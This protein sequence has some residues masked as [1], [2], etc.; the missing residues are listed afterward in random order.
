MTVTA[1]APLTR[2]IRR[3][4]AGERGNNVLGF[5]MIFPLCL[6]IALAALQFAVL[7]QAKALAQGAAEEG[8]RAASAETATAGDG[9]AA[10]TA[11]AAISTTTLRD[12]TVTADR[13]ATTATVTVTGTALSILPGYTLTVTQ[14]AALPVERITG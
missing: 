11:F 13:G 2:T 8:A 12:L 5:V 1:A 3:T 4:I 10:A 14:T 7:Y 9:S 6:L